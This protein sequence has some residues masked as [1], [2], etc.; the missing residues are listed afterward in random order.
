MRNVRKVN[1]EVT[2]AVNGEST[3]SE[4]PKIDESLPKDIIQYHGRIFEIPV[5]IVEYLGN[6]P[7]NNSRI[8]NEANLKGAKFVYNLSVHNCFYCS[9][10]RSDTS[11]MLS[12]EIHSGC[13]YDGTGDIK[14]ATVFKNKDSSI[15]VMAQ[16]SPCVVDDAMVEQLA[17]SGSLDEFEVQGREFQYPTLK[18][19][20]ENPELEEQHRIQL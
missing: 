10:Y 16:K 15:T 4:K 5:E 20:V 13:N 14:W 9:H 2:A 1:L 3:T 6:L 18:E 17:K 7:G 12:D 19:L 11:P 8:I